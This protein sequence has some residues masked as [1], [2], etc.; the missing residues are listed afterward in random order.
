MEGIIKH[1]PELQ[2][3]AEVQS[4]SIYLA[5]GTILTAISGDYQG[6]AGSNHGFVSYNEL[7]VMCRNHQ[8]AYGKS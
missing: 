6:A 7:G 8:S 5:N 3:E 1:N 4:R 2:R